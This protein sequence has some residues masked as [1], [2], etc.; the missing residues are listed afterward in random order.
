MKTALAIVCILLLA[1]TNPVVA[2]AAAASETHPSCACSGC[3]ASC[4]TTD[5]PHPESQPVSAAPVSSL[6]NLLAPAASAAVTWMLPAP[7]EAFLF[8]P[9]ASILNGDAVPLFARNCAR[10]I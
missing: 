5:V 1:L 8:S 9:S 6:Q 10:L 3:G 4:C 2:Q 7:L